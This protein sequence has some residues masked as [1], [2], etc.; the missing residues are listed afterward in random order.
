MCTT[1]LPDL[2]AFIAALLFAVHPIHT[3]AVSTQERG[4]WSDSTKIQKSSTE[5][6]TAQSLCATGAAGLREK[7]IMI[8]PWIPLYTF[9]AACFVASSI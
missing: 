5:S 3:E 6:L 9:F 1:I 7:L 2:T 4:T 8:L